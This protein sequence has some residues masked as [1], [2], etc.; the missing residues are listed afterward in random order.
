MGGA[1]GGRG[2]GVGWKRVGVGGEQELLETSLR[3]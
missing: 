3:C 1:W 2:A